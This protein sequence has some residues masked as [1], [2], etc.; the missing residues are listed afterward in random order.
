MAEIVMDI[1]SIGILNIKILITLGHWMN[2]RYMG[3]SVKT[4]CYLTGLVYQDESVFVYL[5]PLRSNTMQIPS[6]RKE[7]S[8]HGIGRDDDFCLSIML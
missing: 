3:N 5:G 7:F 8:A 4:F 1:I 6:F 2:L